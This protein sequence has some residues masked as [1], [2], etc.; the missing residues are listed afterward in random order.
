MKTA[1][2]YGDAGTPGTRGAVRGVQWYD[3]GVQWY[4]V[5]GAMVPCRGRNGTIKEVQW[6]DKWGAMV[7]CTGYNGTI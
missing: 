2:W 5:A 3:V 1:Q 7:R 4:D 6:Y